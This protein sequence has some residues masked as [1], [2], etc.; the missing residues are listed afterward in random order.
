MTR[1]A[2]GPDRQADGGP[3]FCRIG[4]RGG[5]PHPSIPNPAVACDC[6][7]ESSRAAESGHSTEERH[8]S[9]ARPSASSGCRHSRYIS[10]PRHGER[11]DRYRP[12]LASRGPD[13]LVAEACPR[14]GRA[15]PDDVHLLDCGRLPARP[16]IERS[17]LHRQRRCRP[18]GAPRRLVRPRQRPRVH[19]DR[20]G[21]VSGHSPEEPGRVHRL[22]DHP[23]LRGRRHRDRR[24]ERHGRRGSCDKQ[25]Q[26]PQRTR[27]RWSLWAKGSSRS[28][29]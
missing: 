15:V 28:E 20:R 12:N 10:Q 16:C 11:H 23:S 1:A 6:R 3:V 7:V 4:P 25:G 18:T 5:H 17:E 9:P 29:I 27:P 13:G 22:R 8:V 24:R 21:P 19:R 2:S 14:C 26:P